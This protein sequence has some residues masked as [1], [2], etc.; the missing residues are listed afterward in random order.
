MI[1][2]DK[3]KSLRIFNQFHTFKLWITQSLKARLMLSAMFM[4]VVMLPVIGITLSN[5]FNDQLQGA[6]KNELRAYSYSIFSVAEVENNQL[7]M[8]EQLLE[9]QFNVIQSGLYAQ[10]ST[11]IPTLAPQVKISKNKQKVLKFKKLWQSNSLLGVFF[12]KSFRRPK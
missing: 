10:I 6:L 11:L 4:V 9:N 3:L 5:A 8:P 1:N 7:L 2:L 12:S